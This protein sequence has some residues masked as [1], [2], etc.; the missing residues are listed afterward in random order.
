MRS[1]RK[2][3]AAV[4]AAVLAAHAPAWGQDRARAPARAPITL[5][6]ALTQALARNRD[7]AVS[8]RNIDVSQG[9]LRQAR[10]YPFNPDLNV[11]GQVGQGK[12]RDVSPPE[13]R[14][15][16]GGSIGLSQVIEI[17]GQRGLRVQAA[18]SDLARTEWDV[19]NTEREIVAETTRAF[20]D[21]LL[22]QE[23]VVLARQVFDL[24]TGLRNTARGLVETGA[25][26]EVDVLRA[27]VEVRRA[28]NRVTL[29]EAAV[30][31]ASR[32]L[33][34]LIGAPLE[35]A[36]LASGPLLLEPVPGGLEALRRAAR[37]NRPD[38]KAA[39]AAIKSAQAALDL[40]RAERFVPTV[41]LSAGYGEALDFDST[42]RLALFG[43][44]IPLPIWNSRDGDLQA[45]GG[46][47]RKRES[48]LARILAGIDTEVAT[49]FDQFA[50]AR[51]VVEEYVKQIVP[52]QEQNVAII[53]DGYALGQF[54]ITDALLA[55]RELI[56]TRAGYLESIAAY[57]AVRVELERAV[58]ARP[59]P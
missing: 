28:T 4:V 54:R 57:N 32:A 35:D 18:E 45:A 37:E 33:A 23:Q 27:E 38:V 29:A 17:K 34:L 40:V 5:A 6:E 44:S 41:T 36:L 10:R 39:E 15:L 52:G 22:A 30:S 51:R 14:N 43:I 16:G 24:T 13:R 31:R 46:E 56:E 20:S 1:R 12:G 26:P 25:V 49:A 59:T 58:G 2:A 9:Q 3:V 19:R 7:L 48:D 8:R 50:A 21:L 53:Q 55:Q 42:N 11:E 47:L